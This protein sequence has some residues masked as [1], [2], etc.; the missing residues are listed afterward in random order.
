MSIAK[1]FGLKIVHT[2]QNNTTIFPRAVVA[3]LVL[4]NPHVPLN[5]GKKKNRVFV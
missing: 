5:L 1:Y 4:G 2:Q 3:S